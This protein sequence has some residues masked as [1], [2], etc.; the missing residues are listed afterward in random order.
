VD[1]TV[2]HLVVH[3][4]G[5]G[6]LRLAHPWPGQTPLATP[7]AECTVC[8]LT[9]GSPGLTLHLQPGQTC[10]L[11]AGATPATPPPV[12]E[13]RQGP[14]CVVPGDWTDFAPPVVY[15]PEDLP[16]AQETPAGCVYLGMPAA[17]PPGPPPCP[18]WEQ[19]VELCGRDDWPARQ[20]AARWLARFP[21]RE[22]TDRLLALAQTDAVPVV[23]Y[24]AG[25]SLVRQGTPTALGAALRLAREASLPHLRREILKAVGRLSHTA[26]GA[27]LLA[28]TFGDL[29]ISGDVLG[30]P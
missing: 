20:T 22:A 17:E 21:T 7:P 11:T 2:T 1:G 26:A 24:T 15:Y 28:A 19:V 6:V 12:L 29:K 16:L 27:A 4:L 10:R 3:S 14:R 25:V 8:P 5:G 18:A 23:C 9:D 13:T 30:A